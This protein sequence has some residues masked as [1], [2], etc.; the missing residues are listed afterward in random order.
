MQACRHAKGEYFV[1]QEIGITEFRVGQVTFCLYVFSLQ[2]IQRCV[3]SRLARIMCVRE[4]PPLPEVLR[5]STSLSAR[6]F[7]LRWLPSNANAATTCGELP[8]HHDR[9]PERCHKVCSP[10]LVALSRKCTLLNWCRIVERV[11]LDS[12]KIWKCQN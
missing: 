7:E 9:L 10:I 11:R 1:Y 8:R 4:G 6:Y 12:G 2:E 3:T 5:V